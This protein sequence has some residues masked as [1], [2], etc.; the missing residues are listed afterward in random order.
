MAGTP[1]TRIQGKKKF[2]CPE[3]VQ[4]LRRQPLYIIVAFW[5]MRTETLLTKELVSRVFFISQKTAEEVLRYIE[6]ESQNHIRSRRYIQKERVT[7]RRRTLRILDVQF[8]PEISERAK[9]MLDYQPVTAPSAVCRNMKPL[10]KFEQLRQWML[11]RKRGE[12]VPV[13][14]LSD[15]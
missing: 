7:G 3:I 11:F 15:T 5:G 13:D 9:R 12:Q 2:N 6:H 8:P 1:D 4:D 14:L 10:A